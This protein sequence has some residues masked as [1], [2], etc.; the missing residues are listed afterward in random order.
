MIQKHH[1]TKVVVNFM[2]DLVTKGEK[3]AYKAET[4]RWVILLVFMFVAMMTQVLWL[5]FAPIMVN[6]AGHY[7]VSQDYI[8]LLIAVYMIIYII[9]NF[10]ATWLIDKY[11]LK[12]GT[13]I[14]VI[15]VGVFG[16]LRAFSGTN[17]TFL[18]FTQIMTAV[19]QPFILNSFTKV[20]VNW[21][22]ENEKTAATGI[23][24]MSILIGII[25]GNVVTPFLYESSGIDTVLM[26]YGVLSLASMI[27][28]FV[29][30]KNHPAFPPNEYAGEQAFNYDGFIDMFRNKNFM[31]LLLLIFVGLGVFNAILSEIDVVFS[32]I[33]SPKEASGLIGGITIFGGILGAGILSTISD[34]LKKRVIF[35]Q[36]AMVIATVFTVLLIASSN[37][38]I[39][40]IIAFIY[41]FFLVS[42]LP[43]GLVYAAEITYPVTEEASN[44]LMLT[45]GQVSGLLFL[46]LFILP[47]DEV[48]YIFAFF[49]LV[50]AILSYFLTDKKAETVPSL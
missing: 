10:P 44:G 6:V 27:L 24:T 3:V 37:F 31:I 39:V 47:V 25:V 14:G 19:G 46:V 17:Y 16:F 48:M 28:Y 40:A 7:N 32:S 29:F 38:Y 1:Y 15:L 21:F 23:G 34:A 8:L 49:F 11:G 26:V 41:G 22:P 13:G 5:T 12:W 20:A 33:T 42:G 18:L 4:Y 35:L 9:V 45:M 43:V 30:T 36:A 2:S 50:S